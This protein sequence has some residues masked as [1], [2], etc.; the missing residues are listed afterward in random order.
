M[1]G[2]VAVDVL[3][4]R[5]TKEE[6]VKKFKSNCQ[7]I[8]YGE[9]WKQGSSAFDGYFNGTE[10]KL[11]VRFC[12]REGHPLGPM[13]LVKNKKNEPYEDYYKPE[14][15]Q[16][17]KSAGAAQPSEKDVTLVYFW[18]FDHNEH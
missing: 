13:K 8:F 4:D 9:S 11:N 2:R 3:F 16:D 1:N 15:K 12:R 14:Q 7:E 17:D 5:E 18:E 10:T 6:K